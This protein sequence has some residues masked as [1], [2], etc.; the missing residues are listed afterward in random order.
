MAGLAAEVAF[1]VLPLMIVLIVF[2]HLGKTG[3]WWASNEWPFGAAILF[4]QALVKFMSGLSRGGPAATG[5][6]A[7][8]TA[9]VIV[10]GLAPSLLVLTLTLIAN[11]N[12]QPLAPWLQ[13]AHVVLFITAAAVYLVLGTVAEMWNATKALPTNQS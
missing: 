13:V 11:E 1:A 2:F 12:S 5:P 6:V 8:T 10:G 4:G 7:F 3:R 9:L